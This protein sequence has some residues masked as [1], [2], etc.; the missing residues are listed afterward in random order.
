M[1]CSGS[2]GS[3]KREKLKPPVPLQEG[4][5]RIPPL[6]EHL[7][8]RR[9]THHWT[10][11][12][13]MSLFYRSTR[14]VGK[15]PHLST[16]RPLYQCCGYVTFWYNPD[17]HLCLTDPA[18]TSDTASFGSDFQEGNKKKFKTKFFSYYFLKTHLQN[19]SKI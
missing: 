6:A 7:C 12:K 3:P 18:P 8:R 2:T 15:L 4:K 19:F 10:K 16:A 14:Y 11:K 17:P 9:R 1:G 5:K 13:E